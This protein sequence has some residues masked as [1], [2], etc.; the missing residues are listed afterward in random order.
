[1][2]LRTLPRN[3][4]YFKGQEGNHDSW[5]TQSNDRFC[6]LGHSSLY[7][8]DTYK[9]RKGRLKNSNLIKPY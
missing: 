8:I 3:R 1:M 5:K 9:G 6:R 7:I 4:R 2:V